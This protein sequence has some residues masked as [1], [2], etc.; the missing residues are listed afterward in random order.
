VDQ[1]QTLSTLGG[2]WVSAV[3]SVHKKLRSGSLILDDPILV[4]STEADEVLSQ[5]SIDS[6]SDNLMPVFSR[7]VV[8]KQIGSS[9]DALSCHDVLAAPSPVRVDEAMLKIERWLAI[10]F[11]NKSTLYRTWL[12]VKEMEDVEVNSPWG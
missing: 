3:T 11:P 6:L 12:Q 2:R 9:P 8:T 7:D 4:L 1:L 5:H 10:H